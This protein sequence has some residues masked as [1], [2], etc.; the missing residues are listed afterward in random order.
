MDFSRSRQFYKA[1]DLPTIL[2]Y[3]DY[4][5]NVRFNTREKLMNEPVLEEG[6]KKVLEKS[7]PSTF[8]YCKKFH[9]KM[10]PQ[11]TRRAN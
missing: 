1:I 8:S 11:S 2:H 7:Y 3:K 5:I 6:G 9:E 4:A 10:G